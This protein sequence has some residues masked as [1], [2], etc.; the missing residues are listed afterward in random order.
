MKFSALFTS[1]VLIP[2]A[3]AVTLSYDTSYDDPSRSLTTVAC[4]DGPNGLITPTRTTLG[5]LPHF[6]NV[7]GTAH[8]PGWNSNM[9]GTCWQLTYT[10]SKGVAKSINV[11]AVD[12][13]N[14]GW[15]IAKSAMDTLTGGQ[16]VQLGRVDVKEVQVASSPSLVLHAQTYAMKF[17][18]LLALLPALALGQTTVSVSYDE[19]YD[20]SAGSMDSVACSNGPNGLDPPYS[21]F[22]DLPNFPFIGGAQ[23]IAG[24]DSPNCG[25]CWSLTY[26]TS[27]GAA[28]QIDVL[29]ID[30]ALNGFN[31][32][33]EA[34]NTLTDGQAE[35][36]GR[37]NATAIQVDA[38]ICGL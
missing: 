27:K 3:L 37:V 21:T 24:W 22:G 15:N 23:A 2:T 35:F 11:I 31:I 26:T 14:A 34:M 20:N 6:P 25:T 38:S 12:H 13:A 7:G 33:L 16:A 9:C 30:V 32:A 8:V 28:I 36:L 19:L 10:N 18:A 17:A 4:S 29:A 1:L 5:A